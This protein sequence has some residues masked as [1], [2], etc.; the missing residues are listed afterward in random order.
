MKRLFKGIMIGSIIVIGSVILVRQGMKMGLEIVEEIK[1]E[2]IAEYKIEER[3]RKAHDKQ[4]KV[5]LLDPVRPIS[6]TILA[7]EGYAC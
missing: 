2:A 7:M 4:Y 6:Q 3:E 5:E 1:E